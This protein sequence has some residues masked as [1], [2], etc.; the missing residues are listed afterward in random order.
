MVWR[1]EGRSLVSREFGDRQ[2]FIDE[3]LAPFGLTVEQVLDVRALGYDY[4]SSSASATPV[5][6]VAAQAASAS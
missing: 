2:Q 6:A 1:I 4:A 5:P 3:V